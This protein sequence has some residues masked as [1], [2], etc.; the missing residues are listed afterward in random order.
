MEINGKPLKKTYAYFN[1]LV[2]K[3][4]PNLNLPVSV[5]VVR[6]Y[7]VGD[8]IGIATPRYLNGGILC[9]IYVFIDANGLYPG[10]CFNTHPDNNMLYLSIGTEPN[11]DKTIVQL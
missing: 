1:V 3:N 6:D 9:N 7:K 5:P 11:L 10:I 8:V 4:E 2:E